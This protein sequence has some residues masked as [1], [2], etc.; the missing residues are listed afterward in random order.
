M[1]TRHDASPSIRTGRGISPQLPALLAGLAFA[2]LQG[3]MQSDSGN[4]NTATPDQT[5][6]TAQDGSLISYDLATGTLLPGKITDVKSPTDMQTLADGTLMVNLSGS[7]EILIVDGKTMLQKGPRIPSSAIGAGKPV[8]SYITPELDGRRFWMSLNDSSAA[9]TPNSA[10]FVSLDPDPAKYL[11]AAGEVGLGTGHHKA[12][13]S[14]DKARVVISN[15]A[16]C[17]DIMSVFD[18]TDIGDIRNIATLDSLGAGF[19]GSDKQHICDQSKLRGIAPSPHGCATAK[20]PA[21]ALCNMT[22]NGVL[23]AVDLDAAA[24]G[25]KLIPTQGTGAGYTAAHPGGRYVY[26]LQSAPREGGT[27]WPCQV[28]QVAVADMQADTLVSELPLLYAGPDCKD[29]LAGTPADGSSPSHTLFSP[30]GAKAFI[31]LGSASGADARVDRQLVL[32][33]S[34]PARPKQLASIS[35]GSSNGSHGETMTGDGKWIIVANNKDA[36]VS[37]IDVA[38]ATVSRTMPIDNAGKTMATFG[39]AEGPSHQV[40][41]FH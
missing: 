4:D 3:C 24:P 41:P 21:H 19:D 12:A 39:T 22:G 13:F 26:S 33:V 36:S 2:F 37:I 16:D 14:P 23:V 28:G 35:I 6:F 20:G 18:Y 34:D 32:D 10:R 7:N 29:P 15:I 8:H 27:G 5:L 25:F 11:K 9:G 1:K 40:G 31:N 17:K 38:T 30:D